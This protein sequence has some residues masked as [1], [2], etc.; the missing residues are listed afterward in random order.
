MK[1]N[2]LGSKSKDAGEL[3]RLG[4]HLESRS[5]RSWGESP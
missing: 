1:Y 2:G 3:N 4:M 5:E